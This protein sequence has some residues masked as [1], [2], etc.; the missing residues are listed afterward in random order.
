MKAAVLEKPGYLTVKEVPLQKCG[1]RDIILKVHACGICGSDVRNYKTGLRAA[2]ALPVPGHEFTGTVTDV[3]NEVK[4]FK[5]GDLIAAAPDVSCGE[6]YYCRRGWVNVCDNHRMIGVDWPG[7][8]AEYVHLPEEVLSRGMIHHIPDG[9]S[10]DDAAMSEPASSV[11]ASQAMAGVTLGS[12]VLIIGDG[13]IGCLHIEVARARGASRIIMAGLTRLKEAERFSPDLL[14][15]A[16]KENTPEKV[17][18]AT[19]GLGVDVAICANPVAATQQQAVES[20][21]KKGVVV[22]FGG[23][24]KTSPMTSLDSNRIHYGEIQVIGSFSYRAE[25]HQQALEVIRGG[26]IDPKK[27][28]TL[29]VSL[30]DIND[31]FAAALAGKALKVLVTP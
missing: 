24:P 13:P 28:F 21:R 12:T 9:L 18:K 29:K 14:I 26:F 1:P 31:G 2:V 11:L 23:L 4:R 5:I 17:K 16:G 7:G 20:V 6:C 10:L 30:D 8:F 27:Y 22:L 19:G 25:V 3:G 15:D